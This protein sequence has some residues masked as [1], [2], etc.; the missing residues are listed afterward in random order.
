MKQVLKRQF[1]PMTPE[2]I[3][4]VIL[5]DVGGGQLHALHEYV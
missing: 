1:R 3:E 4:G 2:S 5:L